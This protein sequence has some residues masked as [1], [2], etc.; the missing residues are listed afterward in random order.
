[1]DIADIHDKVYTKPVESPFRSIH[2]G[3]CTAVFESE[4]NIFF[5]STNTDFFSM[6][7]TEIAKYFS[8]YT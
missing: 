4:L 5:R 7:A 2:S 8:W 3:N 1:M 6:A